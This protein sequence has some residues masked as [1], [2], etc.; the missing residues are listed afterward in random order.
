MNFDL[1]SLIVLIVS[2]L[3]LSFLIIKK[4]P[5]LKVMPEPEAIFLKKELKT[6]IREKTKEVIKENSNF[7]ESVLHKL[8]SKIRI[9]SLKTD[10][11]MSDWIKKLRD[12]SVE[13]TKDFDNYWK[14]IKASVKKKKDDGK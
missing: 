1:I 13:R 10:K 5:A 6:K 12:R 11:K 14:E 2:F 8:L 9:L 7:L 3:G 4:I